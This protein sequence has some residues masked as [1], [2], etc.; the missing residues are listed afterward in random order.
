MR[1][2]G[3]QPQT[4][5]LQPPMYRGGMTGNTLGGGTLVSLGQ[6]WPPSGPIVVAV[7]FGAP[8]II[9][10]T[11]VC[12]TGSKASV[13]SGQDDYNPNPIGHNIYIQ[14]DGDNLYGVFGDSA[15]SVTGISPTQVTAI[16]GGTIS[17]NTGAAI[18]P[19]TSSGSTL[20]GPTLGCMK[21]VKDS[22][23]LPIAIP[24][25]HAPPGSPQNNADVGKYSPARYLSLVAGNSG[26]TAGA[27]A[28]ARIWQG[29]D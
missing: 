2:R 20:L 9:D 29:S 10:L 28:Y 15:A 4:N 23:P 3:V 26:S 7:T 24:I 8:V 16:D 18:H 6:T 13:G 22:V 11:T 12:G 19:F 17:G 21:F 25:G 27:P 14:A 5:W 1:F